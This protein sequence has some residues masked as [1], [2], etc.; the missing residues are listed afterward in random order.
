MAIPYIVWPHHL[1]VT[2]E[3]VAAEPYPMSSSHSQCLSPN[4]PYPVEYGGPNLSHSPCVYSYTQ[5]EDLKSLRAPATPIE[6]GPELLSLIIVERT[7]ELRIFWE[8]ESSL[9]N[10]RVKCLYRVAYPETAWLM[11]LGRCLSKKKFSTLWQEFTQARKW[12]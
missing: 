2:R 1:K 5:Q 11:K 3:R 8:N 6:L 12:R 4:T 9:M 7:L 10:D